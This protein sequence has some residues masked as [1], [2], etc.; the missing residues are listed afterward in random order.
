MWLILQ[1]PAND[2]LWCK[3]MASEMLHFF[4]FWLSD[5]SFALSG[6]LSFFFPLI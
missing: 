2:P 3:L 5:F 6:F 1:P 4:D